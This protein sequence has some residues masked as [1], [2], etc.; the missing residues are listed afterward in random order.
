L[1]PFLF[2][3]SPFTFEEITLTLFLG[4]P[5]GIERPLALLILLLIMMQYSS[6]ERV[7]SS[8]LGTLITGQGA[9]GGPHLLVPQVLGAWAS[10]VLSAVVPLLPVLKLGGREHKPSLWSDKNLQTRVQCIHGPRGLVLYRLS[11]ALSNSKAFSL[12]YTLHPWLYSICGS[13][14]FLV[15]VRACSCCRAALRKSWPWVLAVVCASRGSRASSAGPGA[16]W[17]LRLGK[18]FC[19]FRCVSL[20]PAGVEPKMFYEFLLWVAKIP[21][22]QKCILR[23]SEICLASRPS[24]R[25]GLV[26]WRFSWLVP[27]TKRFLC[28]SKSDLQH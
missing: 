9:V 2:S 1:H 17:V 14:W 27:G 18:N 24:L 3:S 21:V 10:S 6:L 22:A 19:L 12:H 8:I 23:V 7:V 26:A 13:L 28:S 11:P 15:L 25:S 20:W 4:A 16:M 5:L